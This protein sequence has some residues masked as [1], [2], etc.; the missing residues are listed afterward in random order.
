MLVDEGAKADAADATSA[1]IS[2]PSFIVNDIATLRGYN[3]IDEEVEWFGSW[4]C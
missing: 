3:I 4:K 2:T 1:Q